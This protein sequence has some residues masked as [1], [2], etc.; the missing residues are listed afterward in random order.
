MPS[1]ATRGETEPVHACRRAALRKPRSTLSTR[2]RSPFRRRS[3]TPRSALPCSTLNSAISNTRRAC[4]SFTV[5]RSAARKLPRIC[6][7]GSSSARSPLRRIS[8]SS[9]KVTRFII[10]LNRSALLRKCQYTAPRVTPAARATCSSEVRDTPRRWNSRSAMSRMRSRVR[11]ASALV[12]RAIGISAGRRHTFTHVCIVAAPRAAPGGADRNKG[13][14]CQRGG[15]SVSK[16][17]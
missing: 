5:A 15:G 9:G 10:A 12:L 16:S 14:T 7:T 13:K 11:C 17:C 6:A 2:P 4:G 3:R 8:L 1:A